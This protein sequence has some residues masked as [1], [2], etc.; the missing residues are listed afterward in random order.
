[1]IKL[2]KRPFHRLILASLYRV[3]KPDRVDASEIDLEYIE[4]PDER[5]RRL[6]GGSLRANDLGC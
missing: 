3:Q 2:L 6:E 5:F 4:P 1:M